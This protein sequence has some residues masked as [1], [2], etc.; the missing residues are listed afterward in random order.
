MTLRRWLWGDRLILQVYNR[1]GGGLVTGRV[2]PL[3]LYNDLNA[4][5]EGDYL[6][7][8]LKQA[9]L[10][11]QKAKSAGQ[12]SDPDF[13]KLYPAI[14]EFM[15]ETKDEENKD[16]ETASL[17]FFVEPGC[18][19]VV[20][21][22]RAEEMSLWAAAETFTEALE[23]LEAQL[24]SPSPPWRFKGKRHVPKKR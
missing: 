5:M 13:R 8:F 9:K 16:R 18:L 24:Q 17:T 22:D 10:Q 20:L 3:S 19:K 11:Q 23:A 21:N 4:E 7:K 15:F 1:F 2:I 12:I 14:A 6:G